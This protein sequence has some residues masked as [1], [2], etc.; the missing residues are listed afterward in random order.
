MRM[1]LQRAIAHSQNKMKISFGICKQIHPKHTTFFTTTVA[2]L[3][4]L[5]PLQTDDQATAATNVLYR[6]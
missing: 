5:L 4:N 3:E 6:E 2:N 1:R